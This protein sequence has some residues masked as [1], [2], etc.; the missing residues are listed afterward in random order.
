MSIV[1]ALLHPVRAARAR[2]ANV[3]AEAER[4]GHKVIH[5]SW[6]G[7]KTYRD[8]IW[9]TLRPQVEEVDEVALARPYTPVTSKVVTVEGV[10]R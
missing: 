3:D 9:D 6:F 8:P 4:R 5:V 10:A 7:R 1:H 2:L